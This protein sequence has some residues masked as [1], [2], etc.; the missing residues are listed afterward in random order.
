M[1]HIKSLNLVRIGCKCKPSFPFMC[2]SVNEASGH[3]S[4]P[5]FRVLPCAQKECAVLSAALIDWLLAFLRRT[6]QFYLEKV[7]KYPW[8]P[9][10]ETPIPSPLC[11][12]RIM[13]RLLWGYWPK[14]TWTAHLQGFGPEWPRVARMIEAQDRWARTIPL[15]G[16]LGSGHNGQ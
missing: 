2:A 15:G 10:E 11:G 5:I 4:R 6:C 12:N 14:G 13:R 8:A 1:F 7:I 3:L 16:M 9:G